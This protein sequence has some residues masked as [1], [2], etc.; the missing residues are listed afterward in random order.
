MSAIYGHRPA[1]SG[2]RSNVC[3]AHV[4]D[5]Q[6]QTRSVK[7]SAGAVIQLPVK[8]VGSE[9][10]LTRKSNAC[11][12]RGSSKPVPPQR[13]RRPVPGTRSLRHLRGPGKYSALT[14]LVATRQTFRAPA[15]IGA[16]RVA[17]PTPR[18][19]HR[20][21]GST[22]CWNLVAKLPYPSAHPRLDRTYTR[23]ERSP[24]IATEHAMNATMLISTKGR[25]LYVR[26]PNREVL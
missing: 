24:T 25:K 19:T 13:P 21:L 9:W 5:I 7:S 23:R 26:R 1:L 2:G 15:T 11:C 10:L 6:P 3:Y 8:V 20:R 16:L 18:S 14:A 22:H 17:R 4:P 12:R